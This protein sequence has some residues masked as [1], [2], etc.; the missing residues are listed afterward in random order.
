MYPFISKKMGLV[1]AIWGVSLVLACASASAGASTSMSP[2]QALGELLYFD[3][4]LSMN[5]NQACASCHLPPTFTDPANSANPVD[6]VVSLGSDPTLNGGRNAPSAAYAKFSPV[7]RYDPAEGIFFGGQFWDGRAP[8]LT[9]Q[10]KGPFLNPVEMAMPNMQAVLNRIADDKGP[11]YLMYKKLWKDAYDVKLSD[12]EG[13]ENKTLQPGT[14]AA[15]VVD[16]FYHMMADAI[17]EFEKTNTFSPFSSKFDYVQAGMASFSPAE[18]NGFAIFEGK[19]GCNACHTSAPLM[20]PSGDLLPAMFTDFSYDNIGIPKSTNPMIA[21]NPVD[22]GLGGRAD[23]AALDPTGGR[24]GKF[25]VMTLRNIEVTAPY[26][27]NGFF[28]TLE[29]IV[30]FYNTRDVPAEGWAAPEVDVNVNHTELG[31]LMLTAD[32][33]ADLVAF[34]KT[35]TDGYGAPLA[36]FHFAPLP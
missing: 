33:E 11:N 6:S 1:K 32:E 36:Q 14:K 3:Q 9:D 15:I 34:L 10:A 22:L 4:N 24:D 7:F 16:R 21:G 23:I 19:A 25:K 20:A 28:A 12:L 30:H 35:L 2:K 31:N 8:T 29:D 17:A 13:N 27:H 18:A 5:R 26:G